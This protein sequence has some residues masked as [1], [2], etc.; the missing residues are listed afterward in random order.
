MKKTVLKII[1]VICSVAV[2]GGVAGYGGSFL[3]RRTEAQLE[4][5]LHGEAEAPPQ[6]GAEIHQKQRAEGVVLSPAGSVT[7]PGYEVMKFRAGQTDQRVVLRNPETNNCA[8]VISIILP[9]GKEIYRSEELRP[10]D[11]IERIKISIPLDAAI[12]EA[13]ILRYSCF[14]LD[15]EPQELNGADS[16]FTLEV[17]P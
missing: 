14:T 9:S 17:I 11:S 10:G 13:S 15:D 6:N 4:A 12:Y 7:I 3:A 5:R 2:I 8:F 1:A 16:L